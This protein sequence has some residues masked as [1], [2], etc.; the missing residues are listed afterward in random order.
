MVIAEAM[1]VGT[2]VITISTPNRDNAQ[3]ELM[4][5]EVSGLVVKRSK[6]AIAGALRYL[7]ETP[8]ARIKISNNSKTKIEKD[9]KAQEIVKSLE[10]LILIH[11][12]RPINEYADENLVKDF[13]Q[14]MM[15]DYKKRRKNLY[16]GFTLL[17]QTLGKLKTIS[18]VFKKT[19]CF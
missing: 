3:I 7:Y 13:S 8:E 9:Y 10:H 15:D 4:D 19:S 5:N 12:N 11:F 1:T 2:P 6:T 16:G 18:M 17:N 14:E